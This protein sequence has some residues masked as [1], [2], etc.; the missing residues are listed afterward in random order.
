MDEAITTKTALIKWLI[1]SA[2]IFLLFVTALAAFGSARSRTRD[3]IRVN[4]VNLLKKFIH[5]YKDN[6]GLYP[7]SSPLNKPLEWEGYLESMPNAPTP[8]D[9]NCSDNDNQYQ[10]TSI[11]QGQSYQLTFCLGNSTNGLS[12]GNNIL[13]P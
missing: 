5:A 1:A 3:Q 2:I 4:D 8:A 9:G 7:A 10:Y 11:S 13:R 6:H 12:A